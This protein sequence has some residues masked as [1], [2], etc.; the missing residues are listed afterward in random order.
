MTAKSAT[1]F[2][3]LVS[4]A[5]LLPGTGSLAPTGAATVAVLTSDPVVAPGTVPETVKVAVA[6]AGKV[7]SASMA[8]LPE[9]VLQLPSAEVQVHVKPAAGTGSA[10]CTRAPV[11]ALGPALRT[12]IV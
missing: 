6:P 11:A 5:W 12:T 2:A 10:S 9:A 4:V 7:T 1:R 3:S 8:P